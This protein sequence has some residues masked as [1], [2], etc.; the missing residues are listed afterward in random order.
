MNKSVKG[1]IRGTCIFRENVTD[2]RTVITVW[3]GTR[4]GWLDLRA[5]RDTLGR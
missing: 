4:G 5:L 3:K 1:C 2:E